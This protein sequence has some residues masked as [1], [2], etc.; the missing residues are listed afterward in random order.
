MTRKILEPGISII[1]EDCD[2]VLRDKVEPPTRRELLD[3]VRDA[4]ALLCLLTEKIDKEVYDAGRKLRVVSTMSV[5]YDH[6]DIPEAT[7]RGI[8]VCYTP[9]VLTNATADFAWTLIMATSR[10][11]VEGDK[12]VR[13]GK[14]VIPWAPDMLLGYEVYGATLGVVGIGRI[15]QA[16][17]E[18]SRGFKM[19]VL[20]YDVVRRT[21]LEKQLGI[22]YCEIDDLLKRS[23]IVTIHVP[24]SKE[25]IGLI[26]ENNLKLMKPSAVVVNTSRGGII[27]ERGLY[28]ALSNGWI[29]AAGLDVH[30]KEPTPMEDPL[31]KLPNIIVAPH[32]ASATHQSRSKMS[33]FAAL[34]LVKVLKGEEPP[35]LV[36]QEVKN[37][38]PLDKVKMI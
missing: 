12:Y 19:K 11:L 35:A 25:T 1:K 24:R 5:G 28:K 7:K 6:V 13:E 20:Y 26:N 18:R 15:G 38:R 21:D 27:D 30:E 29:F 22:E 34:N 10:R 9:G 16:V 8:Y 23:D 2:L 31:L 4:D 37:I 36:N 3:L 32:I 17:I 14:W 33:E